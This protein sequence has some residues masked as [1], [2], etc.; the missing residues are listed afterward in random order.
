MYRFEK[1][2]VNLSL[3]E[4]DAPLIKFASVITKLA[5]SESIHF[6]Y[7]REPVEIPSN[8][9]KQYPWLIEPISSSA[10]TKA[11]EIISKYY[12]G[13]PD[14]S[15]TVEILEKQPTVALLEHSLKSKIDLIISGESPDDRSVAVKLARKAPCSLLFV[16]PESSG[17][18]SKVCL[19]LDM[20]SYSY[21][22]IDI[23]TA[24][25]KAN[26]VKEIDCINYYN[27]PTG[28]HKTN[29]PKEEI[30]KDLEIF[31]EEKL[32]KFL[33]DQNLRGVQAN[34]VTKESH[35]PGIALRIL[36]DNE[37]YDLA[38]VGCRGKDALTATLLGSN[39]EDIIKNSKK[40]AV[41]AV[42][43]KGTGISFLENLMGLKTSGNLF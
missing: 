2:L 40:C 30:R 3:T 1:L 35:C 31:S 26:G 7:S 17:N 38:V 18:F 37:D 19:G 42:K 5:C 41:L 10:K 9:Q 39:A 16:P 33:S 23:A 11:D 36:A 27:I 21:Y 24:F 8:L 13:Y 15:V 4:K 6:I 34:A 43:E 29:I 14:C 32:K 22:A 25:S 12:D 28:Y 20:S